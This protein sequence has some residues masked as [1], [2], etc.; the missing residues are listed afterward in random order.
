L[1]ETEILLA[2]GGVRF[3]SKAGQLAGTPFLTITERLDALASI[4]RSI[5]WGGAQD[6]VLECQ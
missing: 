1:S 6:I 4:G 3:S 5:L 2:Y